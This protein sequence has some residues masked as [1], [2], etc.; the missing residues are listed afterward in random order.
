VAAYAST[1]LLAAANPSQCTKSLNN[2]FVILMSPIRT[3]ANKLL[4]WYN[5]FLFLQRESYQGGNNMLYVE[6]FIMAIVGTLLLFGFN[7]LVTGKCIFC[8]HYTK[9][10]INDT[11]TH[12]ACM[13]T[14]V[15]NKG[16]IP[17]PVPGHGPMTA[18]VERRTLSYQCSVCNGLWLPGDDVATDQSPDT[19]TH[20][21]PDP[22]IMPNNW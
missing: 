4:L 21:V 9:E 6:I 20:I 10:T 7:F 17:C 15:A 11:Y 12:Q 19:P 8:H 18:D 3:K 5:K 14:A 1:P 16:E 13:D 2:Y 22:S